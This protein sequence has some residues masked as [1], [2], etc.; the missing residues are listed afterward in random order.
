MP[1]SSNPTNLISD[2][3]G[4][5]KGSKG[6]FLSFFFL[7]TLSG[8]IYS[9]SQWFF[10]MPHT[11]ITNDSLSHSWELVFA[12]VLLLLWRNLTTHV[13]QRLSKFVLAQSHHICLRCSKSLKG[14]GNT[15][16]VFKIITVELFFLLFSQLTN[17]LFSHHTLKRK[18]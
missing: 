4:M 17:I 7:F 18:Y 1:S 9:Q 16:T 8:H 10:T 12:V 3:R 15:P 5:N 6:P 11:P 2:S 14:K 13:D